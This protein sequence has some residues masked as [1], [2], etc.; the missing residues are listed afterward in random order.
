MVVRFTKKADG[1]HRLTIVRD[2]GSVSQGRVIAGLGP[3]A[4]PHDLLHALV[5]NRLGLSRGVYG[6][7][8][9]GLDI[10]ALLDPARKTL[11]QREAE[12]MHSEA[13][14]TLLQAEDAYEGI[15]KDQLHAELAR[16]CRAL[17]LEEPPISEEQL[18]E[19]RGLRG[20]YAKRWRELEIGRTLEVTVEMR[21][22]QKTNGSR[23]RE[24]RR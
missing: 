15:G 2:D 18:R 3:E 5:E 8:N 12:L 1:R 21:S 7:V 24:R 16:R 4:I 10:A 22:S 13:V 6:M 14:T 19:L 23:R 17:G 11:N 20:E 9:T